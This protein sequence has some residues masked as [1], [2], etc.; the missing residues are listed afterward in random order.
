MTN[1]YPCWFGSYERHMVIASQQ[2]RRE[3]KTT[4]LEFRSPLQGQASNTLP[5]SVRCHLSLTGFTTSCQHY[6]PGTK[7]PTNRRLGNFQTQIIGSHVVILG[8]VSTVQLLGHLTYG[9]AVHTSIFLIVRLLLRNHHIT[10][11]YFH[12]YRV[13][14]SPLKQHMCFKNKK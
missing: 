13:V 14:N 3:R 7:P 6:G 8:R 11:F 1:G 4:R 2:P 9:T 5:L 12:I 10:Q